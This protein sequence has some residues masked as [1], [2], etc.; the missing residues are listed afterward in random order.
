MRTFDYVTF[1]TDSSE[2]SYLQDLDDHLCQVFLY[3]LH[4]RMHQG[5]PVDQAEGRCLEHY[6][7]GF[8]VLQ[9]I[10]ITS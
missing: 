6:M 5:G 8:N 10:H 2:K 7:K 9:L 3:N 4:L 1:V